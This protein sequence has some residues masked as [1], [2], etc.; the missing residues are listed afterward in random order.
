MADGKRYLEISRDGTYTRLQP[1]THGAIWLRS[2][3]GLDGR[4]TLAV[5]S[6]GQRFQT[7]LPDVLLTWGAYRGSRDGLY[8]FNPAGERGYVD[9]DWVNYAID[10]GAGGKAR[11]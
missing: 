7:V 2:T 1:W 3:W 5:S 9:I 4:S 10:N 8:T 6:D 11:D